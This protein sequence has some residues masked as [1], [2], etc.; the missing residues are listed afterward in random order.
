MWK[1]VADMTPEQFV[2]CIDFRYLTDALTRDEALKILRAK[3]ATRGER[4]AQM[5][6]DGYPAWRICA[7]R[8][9][10]VAILRRRIS[11]ASS[12]VSA[13]VRCHGSQLL[14]VMS[15]TSFHTGLR[16]ILA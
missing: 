1:L 4:E 16:W 6:K 7:S 2:S 15:A 13:S 5:R 10:R 11:S 8:S 14:G 9:A 3:F 12:R